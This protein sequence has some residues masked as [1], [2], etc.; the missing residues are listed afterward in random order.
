MA[1][2][3]LKNHFFLLVL[4]LGF[5]LKQASLSAPNSCTGKD[6]ECFLQC[7]GENYF[8]I[9]LLTTVWPEK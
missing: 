9:H 2:H 4:K 7:T 3:S 8:K 6:R 1:T 5:T